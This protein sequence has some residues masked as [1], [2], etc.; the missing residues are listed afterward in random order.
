MAEPTSSSTTDQTSQKPRP[1]PTAAFLRAGPRGPYEASTNDNSGGGAGSESGSGA[2]IRPEMVVPV[3]QKHL[4]FVG[5]VWCY[6]VDPENSGRELTESEKLSLVDKIREEQRAD[7]NAPNN[8]ADRLAY[9]T[10]EHQRTAAQRRQLKQAEAQI[11]QALHDALARS[12]TGQELGGR[13]TQEIKAAFRNLQRRLKLQQQALMV[14]DGGKQTGLLGVIQALAG[15]P[16]Q[17]LSNFD[18]HVLAFWAAGNTEVQGALGFHSDS[19]F[20]KAIN[21]FNTLGQTAR[22]RARLERELGLVPAASDEAESEAAQQDEREQS[23]RLLVLPELSR[24][25]PGLY[26]PMITAAAMGEF[27]AVLL[28]AE[29]AELAGRLVEVA[30]QLTIRSYDSGVRVGDGLTLPPQELVREVDEEARIHRQQRLEIRDEWNRLADARDDAHRQLVQ[31]R[32]DSELLASLGDLD[33]R[34]AGIHTLV[35]PQLPEE[36]AGDFQLDEVTGMSAEVR[37]AVTA[38]IGRV[39]A[40][41]ALSDTQRD[42]ERE[43]AAEAADAS[44]AGGSGDVTGGDATSSDAEAAQSSTVQGPDGQMH[45]ESAGQGETT[46]ARDSAPLSGEILPES[47]LSSGPDSE[48]VLGNEAVSTAASLGADGHA[49]ENEAGVEPA[50]DEVD[51][52]VDQP[53]AV[54]NRASGEVPGQVAD[55]PQAVDDSLDSDSVRAGADLAGAAD[56]DEISAGSEGLPE[57][58]ADEQVAAALGVDPTSGESMLPPGVAGALG[59]EVLNVAAAEAAPLSAVGGALSPEPSSADSYGG[60]SS[61]PGTEATDK[62]T[63]EAGPA[64]ASG[65]AETLESNTGTV[66]PPVEEAGVPPNDAA[67]GSASS[68][69]TP[70]IG[71]KV[72]GLNPVRRDGGDSDGGSGGDGGNV[73]SLSTDSSSSGV[74]LKAG[75]VGPQAQRGGVASDEGAADS[76]T[77]EPRDP[78]S[79]AALNAEVRVRQSMQTGQGS[80]QVDVGSS[81]VQPVRPPSA[82]SLDPYI[83]GAQQ[84][85]DNEGDGGSGAGNGGS[86]GMSPMDAGAQR[87]SRLGERIKGLFGRLRRTG[88]DGAADGEGAEANDS[89]A[90]PSP[91]AGGAGQAGPNYAA[92]KVADS[93]VSETPQ[94]NGQGGA[95]V[96]GAQGSQAAPGAGSGVGPASTTGPVGQVPQPPAGEHDH[97]PAA[98]SERPT[99]TARVGSRDV[100]SRSTEP[101]VESRGGDARPGGSDSPKEPVPNNPP[102]G[103]GPDAPDSQPD[104]RDPDGRAA[105]DKPTPAAQGASAKQ[106]MQELRADEQP[107]DAE[108]PGGEPQE[109]SQKA[110]EEADSKAEVRAGASGEESSP[111]KS[112][113]ETPEEVGTQPPD[114]M[115]AAA[116]GD[117]VEPAPRTKD[118]YNQ[119]PKTTDVPP[120]A[121]GEA[122][123]GTNPDG[124]VESGSVDG[125]QSGRTLPVFNQTRP[126]SPQDGG[127]TNQDGISA[128]PDT[129]ATNPSAP[130]GHSVRPATRPVI[131]RRPR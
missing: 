18:R 20:I 24:D 17:Q 111:N 9:L 60:V 128:V 30:P 68:L 64:L 116:P 125:S 73:S 104:R 39:P 12:G 103:K 74:S 2:G 109:A 21:D 98:L 75:V 35:Q 16:Q 92:L 115:A 102:P 95:G 80:Q 67:E 131:G 72:R 85:A 87:G 51:T 94:A 82:F 106:A 6:L 83:T 101:T 1:A 112:G 93:E 113:S 65:G 56:V 5:D 130:P 77:T 91:S 120:N 40:G 81:T 32:S 122:E 15:S 7:S 119:R 8:L 25:Q 78:D 70:D 127:K 3:S 47:E 71:V 114:E 34:L 26:D 100:R 58:G 86:G 45:A 44:R 36:L 14:G 124:E 118:V 105:A 79:N 33:R 37:E 46:G 28:R 42:R 63:E 61:T 49:L 27:D 96:R 4:A 31:N 84:S 66:A 38:A 108:K 10:A 53:S 48:P 50:A 99:D 129:V 76:E 19:D 107:R 23:I 59:Q 126:W 57:A 88:A 54:D 13:N 52:G 89:G 69:A 110:S 55:E 29:D 123:S 121:N 22:E 117:D 62:T 43:A 11:D 41:T 97:A 90:A